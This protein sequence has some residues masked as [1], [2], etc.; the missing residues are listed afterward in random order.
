[1]PIKGDLALLP[2]VVSDPALNKSGVYWSWDNDKS[3]LWF[4]SVDGALENRVSEEVRGWWLPLLQL[5]ANMHTNLHCRRSQGTA[6]AAGICTLHANR[7]IFARQTPGTC[8]SATTRRAPSCGTC[9][10]S[11]LAL[12]SR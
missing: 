9:P 2:Q 4:D 11:W 8:R 12:R 3:S 7:C 1:M 10:P 6:W 5:A